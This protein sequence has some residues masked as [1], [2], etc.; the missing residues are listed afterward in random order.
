M[1]I[2]YPLH[3][4]RDVQ[5]LKRGASN[6]LDGGKRAKRRCSQSSLLV[7]VQVLLPPVD[8]SSSIWPK[9]KTPSLQAPRPRHGTAIGQLLAPEDMHRAKYRPRS[10]PTS[11]AQKH[12]CSRGPRGQP[13]TG[14][15][16]LPATTQ[17]PSR[18]DQGGRPRGLG[19]SGGLPGER[20]PEW[21]CTADGPPYGANLAAALSLAC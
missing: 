13:V 1:R 8:A 14:S 19:G 21:H 15:R 12:A 18:G 3:R 6:P 10:A 2:Q 7:A 17:R 16:C 11:G 9:K 20:S 5:H 4:M